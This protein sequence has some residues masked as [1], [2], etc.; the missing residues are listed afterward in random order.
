MGASTSSLKIAVVDDD[1][2]VRETLN[3]ALVAHG[4][5][6]F[7]VPN[8]LRLM[9][10]LAVERPDVILLD[11]AMSWID[12]IDLCQA[13]KQNRTYADIP[14]IFLSAHTTPEDLRR[15]LDAGATAYLSKPF[16][17]RLLLDH[18]R[19]IAA[20]PP[21]ASSVSGEFAAVLP[22]QPQAAK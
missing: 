10:V 8:G 22:P 15:G 6:V 9:S 7:L 13:L 14:V 20:N 21:R 1:R 3:D 18:L 4:H 16:D 19:R 11:V 17:L 5:Q 2:D 12:G